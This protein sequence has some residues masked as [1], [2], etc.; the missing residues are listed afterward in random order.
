MLVILSGGRVKGMET[1]E[2]S[3]ELTVGVRWPKISYQA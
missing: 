3:I 2:V 1:I